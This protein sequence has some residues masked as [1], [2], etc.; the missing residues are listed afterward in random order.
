M[1]SIVQTP[2]QFLRMA[3]ILSREHIFAFDTETTGLKHDREMIGFSIAAGDPENGPMSGWYVPVG[4]DDLESNNMD[5][6]RVMRFLSL[7]FRDMRNIIYIHNA[8]FDI[9]TLR[10]HGLDPT[11]IQ[12]DV[13]DTMIMH[14]LYDSSSRKGLKFLVKKYFDYD[15][16]DFASLG[17]KNEPRRIPVK[18]MAPYAVDDAVQLLRLGHLMEDKFSDLG[19]STNKVFKE[20]EM[21]VLFVIEE[22]ENEGFLLDQKYLSEIAK[23]MLE[24]KS[25][26]VDQISQKIGGLPANI[27]STQWLS[28]TFIEQLSW[29]GVRPSWERGKNGY[30]STAAPKLKE[31]ASGR[32]PG[33]TEAG[34]EVAQLLLRHRAISKL[35]STYTT[36]LV[37]ASD[38]K[39]RLHASFNQAGTATGRF[40][41][42]GPNLQNIPRPSDDLPSIRK[43]FIA[44]PGFV[45]VDVDYSQIELRLMAHF[46]Q[47][48]TML[49]T[50]TV[51]GDIHQITADACGSSRQD[52]KALN[53][54]LIYGMGSGSL[55]EHIGKP[56][57]VA[58]KF[59]TKYFQKY[60]GVARYQEKTKRIAT[61][62]G[63]TST[64]IGRRRLLPD[65]K[66][67]DWK[68][69]GP[70]ERQAVNT[71]IQ[72]SAADLI[73]IAMRNIHKEFVDR[74]WFRKDAFMLSQ[75]HDELIFEV[76]ETIVDEVCQVVQESM[77]T[78]VKLRVPLLAE[79]HTGKN[80]EEA[81]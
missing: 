28:T 79:P 36:T 10:N 66:S 76:R 46:S 5:M 69:R 6:P 65:L 63:H 64:L 48:K 74:G 39:G 11:D 45:V 3:E 58:Q 33:T 70:A 19:E 51:G 21:P 14:H 50:Y 34:K 59:Y 71:K 72:G 1:K 44:R 7:L 2:E 30:Y 43:A 23:V 13:R 75:V 53:F 31:W 25:L 47:D 68:K 9:K 8:K 73:K 22:M 52:A 61:S 78:C 81:K 41:S 15:M 62:E 37:E 24:E 20:L 35:L 77:E 18:I 49:E 56:L 80:W 17:N 32:V 26:I 60:S 57:H 38:D 54:G 55:A 67:S 29:W 4:H 42:S 27:G 40:S 12:A 16:K